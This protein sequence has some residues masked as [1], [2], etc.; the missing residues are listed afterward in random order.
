[1]T[2][3]GFAPSITSVYSYHHQYPFQL[4]INMFKFQTNKTLL[5]S[6][7]FHS[8]ASQNSSPYFLIFCFHP[9]LLDP[10]QSGLCLW[11]YMEIDKM[12]FSPYL[13]LC[14]PCYS[15]IFFL[16]AVFSLANFPKYYAFLVPSSFLHHLFR[17]SLKESP[18][19]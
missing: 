3:R 8:L 1:M 7:S 12:F 11:L 19:Q 18:L 14:T 10:E 17:C 4:T 16:K 2:F 5:R 13:S 6:P 15:W 9:S